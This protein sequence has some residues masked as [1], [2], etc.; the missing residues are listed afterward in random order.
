MARLPGRCS[1]GSAPPQPQP[2]RQRGSRRRRR[3]ARRS[4]P[5]RRRRHQHRP[6]AR[7]ARDAGPAVRRRPTGAVSRPVIPARRPCDPPDPARIGARC[8]AV[9]GPLRSTAC[10]SAP[11]QPS[12]GAHGCGQRSTP[13]SMPTQR[14]SAGLQQRLLGPSWRPAPPAARPGRPAGRPVSP[15]SRA[16]DP[17]RDPRPDPRPPRSVPAPGCRRGLPWPRACSLKFQRIDPRDGTQQ[18]ENQNPFPGRAST[19]GARRRRSFRPA[20]ASL[21]PAV[22]APVARGAPCHA[23][24][25]PRTGPRAVLAPR[26]PGR[27]M[28]GTLPGCPS[29]RG[30]PPFDAH[31]SIGSCPRPAG[32][33]GRRRGAP[34]AR[35]GSCSFE[36][37]PPQ[38]RR[39]RGA[40]RRR[41]PARRRRHQPR[42]P[43]RPDAGPAV[44]RRPTGGRFPA[45]GLRRGLHG[46]LGT[47]RR[48]SDAPSAARRRTDQARP[49]S[50]TSSPPPRRRVSP[51]PR[52]P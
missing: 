45:P 41:R 35:P 7:P 51:R 46:P 11:D 40:P 6:H 50:F 44:R 31:T 10:R 48:L 17:P 2:R 1:F 12:N 23:P 9:G 22:S 25:R 5:A 43:A 18:S 16:A 29:R 27:V 37:A 24:G 26:G 15:F 47:A 30:S 39:H 49:A 52:P 32:G 21:P 42:P 33:A 36:S 13:V 34:A 3:R 4:T 14:R 28:R 8:P 20:A 19:I 38:P